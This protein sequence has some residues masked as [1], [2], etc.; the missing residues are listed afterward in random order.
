M[1]RT[2]SRTDWLVTNTVFG[3][4]LLY[5]SVGAARGRLYVP[6]RF[7]DGGGAYLSGLAAWSMAV[8]MALLWLGVSVRLGLRPT[9]VSKA[10]AVLETLLLAAG[11]GLLFASL[12]LPGVAPS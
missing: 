4:A 10:R 3:L 6:Y 12:H 5:C 2:T 11:L 7:G 1:P 8:A 9:M